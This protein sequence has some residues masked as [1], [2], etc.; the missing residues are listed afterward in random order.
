MSSNFKNFINLGMKL[1]KNISRIVEGDHG[2]GKSQGVKQI[3]EN[4]EL[5]LLDIRLALMTEGDFIGIPELVDVSFIDER[6][7][8]KYQAELKRS[9]KDLSKGAAEHV[10]KSI[11]AKWDRKTSTRF[12]PPDWLI[13]C[14]NQPYVLLLDEFNRASVEVKQAAFQLILD[15]NI[16]GN[17]LHPDTIVFAAINTAQQYHVE[18][19][20]PALYDRF[21][22]IKLEPSVD[23]WVSWARPKLHPAIVDFI[24]QYPMHLEHKDDFEP[25]KVYPSRRSWDRFDSAISDIDILEINNNE[26]LHELTFEIAK[27]LVGSEAAVAFTGFV[28]NFKKNVSADNVLDDFN[29]NKKFIDFDDYDQLNSLI[30]ALAIKCKEFNWS[31]NQ[32]ENFAKFQKLLPPELV[33]TAWRKLIDVNPD[34]AKKVHAIN[35]MFILECI[36]QIDL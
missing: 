9:I 14:A 32:V 22:A 27:S 30:E 18:S 8:K 19:L 36:G 10:A 2:I 13:K 23:D 29:K 33:I 26:D 24:V 3:A 35:K 34:N 16:N 6:K 21:A 31:K 25:Y 1:P 20:D 17:Y 7:E 5:P 12:S 15:R 28:R 11:R 4:L